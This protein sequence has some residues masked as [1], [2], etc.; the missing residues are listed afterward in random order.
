MI[1]AKWK[2]ME[3]SRN[4]NLLFQSMR[5]GEWTGMAKVKGKPEK[6]TDQDIRDCQSRGM[7]ILA[8]AEKYEVTAYTV[9]RKIQKMENQERKKEVR[10]RA[11]PRERN[12]FRGE[13]PA[14]D[15]E[16]GDI[17]SAIQDEIS[18]AR[19]RYRVTGIYRHVYMCETLSGKYKWSTTFRKDDYMKAYDPGLVRLVERRK[20]FEERD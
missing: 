9:M 15:L 11:E 1:T 16:V 13:N 5:Q 10:G 8:I 7:E 17:V 14:F 19:R 4:K 12:L 3:K 20:E 18:P 6:I 2:M